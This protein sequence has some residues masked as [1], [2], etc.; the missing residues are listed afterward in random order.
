MT[1]IER[2]A[3]GQAKFDGRTLI[4]MPR[5]ERQRYY[6]RARLAILAI[7]EPSERMEEAA[8]EAIADIPTWANLDIVATSH[9]AMIDAALEETE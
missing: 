3:E 5:G 6:E 2:V 7:R 9:R 1:M 8:T 4:A